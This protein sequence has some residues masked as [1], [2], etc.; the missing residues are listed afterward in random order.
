MI[1][2]D[3]FLTTLYVM[4]DDFCQSRHVHEKHIPG[5]RA[6]LQCSEVITLAVF[7]QWIQF[8]SERAFYRYAEQHLQ[9]AFPQLPDR[10]QFNRLLREYRDV[11]TSFGLYLVECLHNFCI[12]FNLHLGRAPLAFADLLAW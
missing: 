1:D 2:V 11:I 4:V 8:P 3:T 5:P 6:S 12:W 7:G 10:A 9:A